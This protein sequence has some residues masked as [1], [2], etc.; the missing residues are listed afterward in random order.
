MLSPFQDE[1]SSENLSAADVL[2]GGRIVSRTKQQYEGKIKAIARYYTEQLSREF[3][4]PAQRD[5]ILAFF[6]WL[7]D[8]KHKDEPLAISSVKMY[9]SALKWFYKE[10]RVVMSPEI[11]QELDTLM[12][13]YQRRVSEFKLDGKMPVFEGK[14][15]LPFA[16]YRVLASLLF[17][18]SAFGEMLFAWPFL[19]LQWNLIA[20]TATVSSMMMEHI[21]WEGDALLITTPKHKGDQEGV[22]CFARHVYANPII[23]AICP[24]LALAIVTFVRTL[25]H[26]P[27]TSGP[28]APASFRVFDGPNSS[29]RFSSVLSRIIAAVPDAELHLL[30]GE[31]KQLGTHSVRKGA[32]SYCAGMIN[33]PSTVQVFLR[34]GWSLGNVQDRYLFAGAGGDQ[35]TG[36]VLSGLPFNDSSFA[37]LPPHFEPEGT[38]MIS[39]DSIHP[40]YPRLPDTFKQALPHLLASICYHESW[41]RESLAADHPLFSTRLFAS[42]IVATLKPHVVTGSTRCPLTGLDATGIP[43]HLAMANEL[44]AVVNHTQQLKEAL[45]SRCDGLPAEVTNVMLS[46]FSINGAIPLTMDNM[47]DMLNAVVAQLRTEMRDLHAGDTTAL[48]SLISPPAHSPFDTWS[49]GGRLHPVPQGWILPSAINVK[50]TWHLWHFGHR[51]CRIGPLRGLKKFDLSSG[52]QVTLWSK[53]RQTMQA[54]AQVMVDMQLVRTVKDVLVL[55]EA[56]SS[57]FFDSAIVTWMN[58]LRAGTTQGRGRWMEM[59]IPTMYALMLKSRKRRREEGE[60]DARREEEKEEEEGRTGEREEEGRE[61]GKEEEREGEEEEDST[62]AALLSRL[63]G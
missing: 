32:A 2:I 30:G 5:D 8:E 61:E 37:S 20:R 27:S 58:K 29:A 31:K 57:A 56:D 25:R 14:Y 47:R 33:G 62:A 35:L 11:N 24:V 19:V 44:T 23:P 22:K 53:T 48:P 55:S 7:I 15:H 59:R 40:L 3:V 36:R 54:I 17:R 34:A 28:A 42:G 41:L 13:G 50:D 43:P 63:S 38:Q 12:K 10:H 45:L 51:A 52:A 39:W 60:A 6:G 26:D 21:G 4:V 49:W 16:G 46:K 9:K 18:S 1:M